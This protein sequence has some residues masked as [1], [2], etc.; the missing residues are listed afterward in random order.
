MFQSAVEKFDWDEH[1]QG[2]ILGSYYYGY[3]WIQLGTGW[4]SERVG[5]K[6]AFGYGMLCFSFLT[7]I[8]PPVARAGVP[9]LVTLR[10]VQGMAEV[11]LLFPGPVIPVT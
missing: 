11:S 8:T 7:I 1:T 10:V 4:L 2:L 9:H 5:G 6:R 3:T